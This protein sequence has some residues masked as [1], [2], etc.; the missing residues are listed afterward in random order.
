M[1]IELTD[2]SDTLFV[3]GN[4]EIRYN[5]IIQ[6]KPV[7]CVRAYLNNE[8]FGNHNLASGSVF[9]YTL[10]HNNGCY[11]LRIEINISSGTGSV[12]EVKQKEE[13]RVKEH[14]SLCIDNS[15]P[16]PVEI[17]SIRRV[18]GT[19]ELVWERYPKGKL[20]EVYDLKILL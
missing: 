15:K 18:D 13:L 9:L 4:A 11:S 17:T 5:A 6:N 1:T 20:P 19:L 8:Q 10:D 7:I 12:A 14:T 2:A 16:D 3:Y